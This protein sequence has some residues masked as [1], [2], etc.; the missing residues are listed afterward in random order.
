M[1]TLNVNRTVIA[2]ICLA[3]SVGL[4]ACVSETG[5]KVA[6]DS[7]SAVTT[8]TTAEEQRNAELVRKFYA[9]VFDKGDTSLIDQMIAADYIEHASP[10]DMQAGA[11]DS[12]K[13]YTLAYR[14]AF[15]DLKT[16]VERVVAEGDIVFAHFRQ[17]GTSKGAFMGMPANGK[18]FDIHGVDVIRIR[19]GKAVEHWGYMEEMKLASQMGWAPPPT[20]GSA[21]T[22]P[23]SGK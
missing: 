20:P 23:D 3:T 10:V 21:A 13:S 18:Q 16:E 19:D 4:I 12:L 22:P 1:S 2:A 11:R 8:E 7:A 6:G 15:P 9:E 5:N 17:T 14:A